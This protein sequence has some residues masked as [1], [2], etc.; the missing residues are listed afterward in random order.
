MKRICYPAITICLLIC[1]GTLCNCK[2]E[3]KDLPSLITVIISSVTKDS[4]LLGGLI[5]NDGGADITARGVCYGTV[6]SPGISG[7]KTKNGRGKGTFISYLTGLTPNTLY[8]ARAYATNSEGTGYG[9]EINFKTSL[10]AP[11][12]A[13]TVVTV[14][15]Y[16]KISYYYAW[17]AGR[18]ID[19]GGAA[20]TEKGIC[21]S[22]NEN[23]TIINGAKIISPDKSTDDYGNYGGCK[24]DSLQ[25]N[26][27][28]YAKAYVIN[29]VDTS[30]GKRET[31]KTLAV[32]VV[33]TITAFEITKNSALVSGNVITLADA[34]YDEY[35]AYSVEIEIGISYGTDKDPSIEGQHIKSDTKV[36][37][38]F[39]CSLTNLMTGVLYHARSYVRWGDREVYWYGHEFEWIVYGNEITF[40]TSE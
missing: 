39:K 1:I 31:I 33:S 5:I 29:S 12:V 2:K 32:P 21:W 16:E 30:Y 13:A 19:D 24:I 38:E 20:I 6:P 9:N 23:P 18:I 36:A 7:L 10:G 26:S 40:R 22:A 11:P 28:Y 8:Y 17:V 37:G 15:D 25:P 3:E 4:A 34:N 14:L 35:F 27:I